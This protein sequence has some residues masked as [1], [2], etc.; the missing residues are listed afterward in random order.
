MMV[1]YEEQLTDTKPSYAY[2]VLRPNGEQN[3]MVYGKVYPQNK[4]S[5]QI[6]EKTINEL[7]K[8]KQNENG[9]VRKVYA[10]KKYFR[11]FIEVQ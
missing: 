8:S 7:R 11:V 3:T 9:K 5:S 2:K 6:I 1:D 10:L 4:R